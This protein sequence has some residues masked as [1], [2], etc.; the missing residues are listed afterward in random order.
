MTDFLPIALAGFVGVIA[1]LIFFGGLW[2]TT[3]RLLTSNCPAIWLL[4]S[5]TVRVFVMLGALY[6]VGRDHLPRMAACLV[7]FVIA[8]IVM[9][10]VTRERKQGPGNRE[11]GSACT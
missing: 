5:F 11:E 7:G 10:Y 6:W 9:V 8:R 4:V 3:R 1:G 2:F